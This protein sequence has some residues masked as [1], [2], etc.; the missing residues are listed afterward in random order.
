VSE[1][2]RITALHPVFDPLR[3]AFGFSFRF[4]S[5]FHDVFAFGAVENHRAAPKAKGTSE[6]VPFENA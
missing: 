3:S 1:F 6:K 2:S 5:E 4:F